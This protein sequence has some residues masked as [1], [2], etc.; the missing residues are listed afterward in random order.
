MYTLATGDRR[1]QGPQGWLSSSARDRRGGPRGEGGEEEV[2]G[3][4][5]ALLGTTSRPIS[6]GDALLMLLASPCPRPSSASSSGPE[7]VDRTVT[8]EE[9]NDGMVSGGESTKASRDPD[10]RYT[11][12][13]PPLFSSAAVPSNSNTTTRV[14][15]VDELTRLVSFLDL[16]KLPLGHEYQSRDHGAEP[17]NGPR[18]HHGTARSSPED[19]YETDSQADTK[20]VA[21]S[22]TINSTAYTVSIPTTPAAITTTTTITYAQTFFDPTPSTGRASPSTPPYDTARSRSNET[23]L[24][25]VPEL[26][27]EP[28]ESRLSSS[29]SIYPDADA[30]HKNIALRP[31]SAPKTSSSSSNNMHPKTKHS[32][33]QRSASPFQFWTRKEKDNRPQSRPD[34]Y[35]RNERHMDSDYIP[36]VTCT[37]AGRDSDDAAYVDSVCNHLGRL[38]PQTRPG[39]GTPNARR[40]WADQA[41]HEVECQ[42]PQPPITREEYMAL[43]EAIQRKVCLP[44]LLLLFLLLLILCPF[45]PSCKENPAANKGTQVSVSCC[46]VVWVGRICDMSTSRL[47]VFPRRDGFLVGSP[48]S[49]VDMCLPSRAVCGFKSGPRV[50][51]W[52]GPMAGLLQAPGSAVSCACSCSSAAV[53]TK[54]EAKHVRSILSTSGERGRRLSL[55]GP[56]LAQR[57]TRSSS[58]PRLRYGYPAS[59]DRLFG[60]SLGSWTVQ[61]RPS[62]AVDPWCSRNDRPFVSFSGWLL[63][64]A[65]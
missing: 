20:S 43:P 4:S 28:A 57:P 13:D 49:L 39:S 35:G 63:R 25:M 52:R 47:Q 19:H 2:G 38:T 60:K 55:I 36:S 29:F 58:E 45:L 48:L 34:D 33:N 22:T 14:C 59:R 40:D 46:G 64:C 11:D 27:L 23:T 65:H 50:L 8:H 17:Q 31:R 62:W 42:G 3:V 51:G 53:S 9:R 12:P 37:A 18:S 26:S 56:R 16:A 54:H 5:G 7:S 6:G 24:I 10:L 1:W 21:S 61:A 32:K 41:A 15:L 30:M 44:M